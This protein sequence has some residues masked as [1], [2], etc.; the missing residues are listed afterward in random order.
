MMPFL[1]L[2]S[3]EIDKFKTWPVYKL[4][5]IHEINTNNKSLITGK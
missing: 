2:Y 1:L 4:H 3:P 5:N